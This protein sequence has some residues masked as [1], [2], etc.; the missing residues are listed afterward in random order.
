MRNISYVK[1]TQT[2]ADRSRLERAAAEIQDA[3]SA[4]QSAQIAYSK[5]RSCEVVVKANAR[6]AYAHC[7]Y[8]EV[9]GGNVRDDR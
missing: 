7:R 3:E 1:E 4:V 9:S 8:R 5:G 6:L 2:M